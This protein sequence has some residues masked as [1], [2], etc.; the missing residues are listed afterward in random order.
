MKADNQ[1]L[2]LQATTLAPS[3][4]E[5]GSRLNRERS[6]FRRARR[7]KVKLHS[8]SMLS[9][10]A[11]R[12]AM[13]WIM[14]VRGPAK[15]ILPRSSEVMKR[16][17]TKTA[18]GA[19]IFTGRNIEAMEMMV[20]KRFK[21]NSARK[22][23]LWAMDLWESSWRMKARAKPKAMVAKRRGLAKSWL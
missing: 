1:A 19:R 3:N 2:L 7:R 12:K 6:E 9:P 4:M 17:S 20:P 21:R 18:P 22:P 14:L 23:Y 15:A 5:M 8:N 11:I 16:P 10:K 13:A